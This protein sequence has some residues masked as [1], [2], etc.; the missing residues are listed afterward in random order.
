VLSDWDHFTKREASKI[1]RERQIS[2][3]A[4]TVRREVCRNLLFA[5]LTSETSFTGHALKVGSSRLGIV[6]I[7]DQTLINRA[8][9]N[10]S[11]QQATCIFMSIILRNNEPY[12]TESNS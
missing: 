5:T 9:K 1:M 2:K 3:D 12:F 11:K 10:T 7:A 8:Y 6:S 4:E